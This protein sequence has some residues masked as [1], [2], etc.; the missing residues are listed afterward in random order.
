MNNIF[1]HKYLK[2]KNKYLSLQ[3]ELVVQ[4]IYNRINNQKGGN[5]NLINNEY[6]INLEDKLIGSGYGGISIMNNNKSVVTIRWDYEQVSFAFYTDK[7]IDLFKFDG[8]QKTTYL[9]L[10]P[11]STTWKLDSNNINKQKLDEFKTLALELIKYIYGS[12]FNKEINNEIL[13]KIIDD[14]RTS[15]KIP[16]ILNNFRIMLRDISFIN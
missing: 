15:N 5:I 16:N 7:N 8:S 14:P 13:N 2:Y 1:T 6:S 12:E 10:L 3:K 11:N 9:Y 4:S